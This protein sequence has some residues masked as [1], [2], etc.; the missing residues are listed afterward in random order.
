M[1]F[2]R[3][4]KFENEKICTEIMLFCFSSL[5]Y[6]WQFQKEL[7]EK[8][9]PVVFKKCIFWREGEALFFVTFNKIINH[10]FPEIFIKILVVQ[11]IWR[12][13]PSILILFVNF[14]DFLTFPCYKKTN[15]FG[16]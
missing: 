4:E 12:F 13:Y 7:M 2:Q 6:S 8:S 3:F 1:Q 10:I 11:K 5:Y 16:I 15:E 9:P 14:S